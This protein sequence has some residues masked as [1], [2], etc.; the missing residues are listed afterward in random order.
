[1]GKLFSEGRNGSGRG[2][3][4]EELA[5]RRGREGQEADAGGNGEGGGSG[6]KGAAEDGAAVGGGERSVMMTRPGA[7]ATDAP[8]AVAVRMEE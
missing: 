1:M 7:V 3:G 8:S 4:N 5:G 2:S 6:R